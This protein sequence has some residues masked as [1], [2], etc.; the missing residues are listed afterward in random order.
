MIFA[1]A[2]VFYFTVRPGGR[3]MPENTAPG[4]AV[5][6]VQGIKIV[7]TENFYGDIARQLGGAD[8]TVRSII[9]NPNIDPHEY[10]STVQDGV[11]VMKAD[12]VIKNG[13]EYDTW[14]DKL[15]SAS[16]NSGRSVITAGDI[17][18]GRLPGNPH[19]WYGIVNMKALA[20]TITGELKKR[21]PA[22]IAQFEKNLD[23]FN[24]SLTSLET[25]MNGIRSRFA[26]T[27]VGLTETI[28]LY[29]TGPMG[30]KV[31]TPLNFQR[32]ISEGN[33]PAAADLAAAEN[34]ITNRKI[35]VLIYNSQTVTPVTT[36]LLNAAQA[37]A[38]PVVPVTET[39]PDGSSYQSWMKAELNALEK[40]LASKTGSLKEKAGNR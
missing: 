4:G 40:G 17:A 24:R 9:S 30:L 26:G 1:A 22:H 38:I 15:L 20:K 14:M 25:K 3:E 28:C 10:E 34:Q 36:N 21:D 6:P 13:L 23:A 35:K 33:E 39:M 8:V 31:L 7:A 29:Q 16:P 12:I 37:R 18:P 11:A 5:R 19:V 2:A 27:P 32:A